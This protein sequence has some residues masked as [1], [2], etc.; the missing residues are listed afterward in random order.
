MDLLQ[1]IAQSITCIIDFDNCKME[2]ISVKNGV[3]EDLDG[4]R[5][6]YDGLADFLVIPKV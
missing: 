4:L 5:N 6:S 2:H 3:C 1:Q